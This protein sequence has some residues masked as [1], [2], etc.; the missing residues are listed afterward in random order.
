M[1][2]YNYCWIC[3]FIA[4]TGICV[5]LLGKRLSTEQIIKNRKEQKKLKTQSKL[6]IE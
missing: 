4:E 3:A 2:I 5:N 6:Q 1:G